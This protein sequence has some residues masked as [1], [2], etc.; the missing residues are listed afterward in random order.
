M[1]RAD[2]NTTQRREDILAAAAIWAM[3]VASRHLTESQA[4]HPPGT[5][6]L[7]PHRPAADHQW[8]PSDDTEGG[9]E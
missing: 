7:L 5:E 8:L 4:C 1:T 6:Y 9:A 3:T 2:T